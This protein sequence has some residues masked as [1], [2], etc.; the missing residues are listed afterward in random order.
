M[1][2]AAAIANPLR[3]RMKRRSSLV[4]RKEHK[5]HMAYS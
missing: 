1:N 2:A 4:Q 5:E 3:L